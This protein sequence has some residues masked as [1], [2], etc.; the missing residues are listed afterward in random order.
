M[1][2]TQHK[3][4]NQTGAPRKQ[5]IPNW[6]PAFFIAEVGLELLLI[7]LLSPISQVQGLWPCTTTPTHVNLFSKCCSP[8]VGGMWE[9]KP[10]IGVAK[11]HSLWSSLVML[12]LSPY[13]VYCALPRRM[14]SVPYSSVVPPSLLIWSLPFITSEHWTQGSAMWA[15]VSYQRPWW[16]SCPSESPVNAET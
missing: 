13:L 12:C 10:W 16:D 2:Q 6:P 9:W 15:W 5:Q 3:P 4:V 14:P 11:W 1:T 7:L 8:V